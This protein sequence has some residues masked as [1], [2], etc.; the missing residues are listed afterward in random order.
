MKSVLAHIIAQTN[1]NEQEAWWMLQHITNKTKAKLLFSEKE[2]LSSAELE[3]INDWIA[4][5]S[6][7]SIPLTYLLGSIPF[8][9]LTIKTKPP[10]LI[11]RIETEEWVA[12]LIKELQPHKEWI[13]SI[14]EIG[15]GS[16]C[17]A[18]ALAKNFIN[19]AVVATDINEQALQL[20]AENAKTNNI[21]N[22]TFMQSDLFKNIPEDQTFDLII[23][24]P[25]YIDPIHH[26]TMAQ[27][28]IKWEDKGALFAEEGGLKLIKQIIHEAPKHLTNRPQLPYQLIIEHDSGQEREIALIAQKNS[29]AC[30]SRKDLFNNVRTSWCKIINNKE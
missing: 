6:E 18:L 14:L 19:S 29:F 17:I 22:V 28:V 2:S 16:G 21:T 1:L 9:D 5:L 4:Q 12:T 27:Q 8:L 26:E 7:K 11:P 3:K 30:S 23:S 25:P 10:I 13:K 15:T 20:A 24:N